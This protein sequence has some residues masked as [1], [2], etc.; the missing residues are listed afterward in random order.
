MSQGFTS[1]IPID[2]DGTLSANSN[3]LIPSQKAVKT[4]VDTELA[5]KQDLLYINKV[6]AASSAVTGTLTETECYKVL[7]PANTLVSG[8]K[9]VLD[10]LLVS[11]TGTA[12]N[13]VIRIK[14]STS[15]T[16]PAG[17]TSRVADPELSAATL[18]ITGMI[19]RTWNIIGGNIY[20][21][22]RSNATASKDAY[23]SDPMSSQA[24]DVTVDNYLYISVILAN[25]ADSVTLY[26]FTLKNF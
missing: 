21:T 16:L 5:T 4:Y 10:G 8:D 25:I 12:G 22:P 26:G 24:F 7:I 20:G 6:T 11:K 13:A 23:F 1:G 15:A 14:I 2:T 17:T 9:L 19:S 3:G 18:L